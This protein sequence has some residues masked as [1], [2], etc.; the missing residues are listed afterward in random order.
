VGINVLPRSA[1][2]TDGGEFRSGFACLQELGE[3]SAPQALLRIAPVLLGELLRFQSQGLAPRLADWARRDVMAGRRVS[4]GDHQGVAEGID[5]GG[6]LLLRDNTG[7][8]HR[9]ASG[10]VSVRPC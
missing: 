5:A 2:A 3:S 1:E 6:E 8:L 4:A 10:E 7:L 9:I